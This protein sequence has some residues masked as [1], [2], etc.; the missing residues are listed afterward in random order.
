[1][2]G[3]R[4]IMAL[5]GSSVATA[6]HAQPIIVADSGDSAW[7]LTASILVLIAALPGAMLFFGRSRG[8]QAGLAM[9]ASLSIVTLLF[10]ILGYSVAFSDGT[11]ILGGVGNMMLGGLADVQPDMTI[12]GPVYALFELSIALFAIGILVGSVAQRARFGW[13]LA[14]AGLWSLIVYVPV[15]H[16]IWGGGWLAGLGALDYAGGIVVQVTAGVAALVIALF[17]GRDPASDILVD[18]RLTMAGAALLCI[19]WLALIGGSDFAATSNAAEAVTNAL[20]AMCTSALAGLLFERL[21]NGNVSAIGAATSAVAGLAAVSAGAG[22]IGPAGAMLIGIIGAIGS[23]LAASLVRMLKLGSTSTAFVA[24]GGAAILG[25]VFF[26]VFVLSAFGGP[27]FDDGI[28]LG[29]QIATQGIAV[30]AVALW[31]AIATAIAALMISM[32]L[33]MTDTDQTV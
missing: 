25:S 1:M 32:V 4:L 30:V 16:W 19:G 31:T 9:F 22:Y 11:A 21:Q 14:F 23:M 3:L 7:M 18:T 6:A 24:N 29:G 27:G 10:A 8:G 15:A 28:S 12:P 13:L 2:R 5:L 33:P 26:P 17:M 20:L